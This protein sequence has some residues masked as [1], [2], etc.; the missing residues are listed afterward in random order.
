MHSEASG[1]SVMLSDTFGRSVGVR[2]LWERL[3]LSLRQ[4]LNSFEDAWAC[5]STP[6]MALRQYAI[7]E[8]VVYWVGEDGVR[9]AWRGLGCGWVGLGWVVHRPLPLR[10]VK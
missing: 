1:S 4:Y 2:H 7:S 3:S 9:W 8:A 5:G 10:S 6:G